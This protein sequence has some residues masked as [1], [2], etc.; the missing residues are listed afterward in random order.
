MDTDLQGV[1]G[2][3]PSIVFT[4]QNTLRQSLAPSFLAKE[5]NA[6]PTWLGN[7][8]GFLKC[9]QCIA[10][11]TLK[12]NEKHICNFKSNQTNKQYKINNLITCDTINVVYL[13]ECPCKKQYIG[14][15]KHFSLH[16]NNDPSGLR[17]TG[18]AHKIKSWR[19]GNNV[20]IISQEETRW[21][22]TLKTMQPMGLNIDLDVNCFI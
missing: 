9:M 1:I 21:I 10:C 12:N 18:I 22:I 3:R 5:I 15:T 19:G 17:F 2:K 4:R 8:K 16:H 20:Q 7:S 11:K 6:N 14:R 13:L